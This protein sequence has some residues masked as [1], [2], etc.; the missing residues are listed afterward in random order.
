MGKILELHSFTVMIFFL[1][2]YGIII[3]G[4]LSSYN[5]DIM[6]WCTISTSDTNLYIY[7]HVQKLHL[8]WKLK[9]GLNIMPHAKGN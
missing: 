6:A 9:L 7:S 4:P 5:A 3:R 8:N 2:F 1:Q